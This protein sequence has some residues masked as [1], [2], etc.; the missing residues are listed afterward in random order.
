MLEFLNECILT[1]M[2]PLLGWLLYL[3]SDA[4]LIAI[5]LLSA[6]ALTG[7]RIVTTNQDLL[8]R[9][10]EDKRRLKELAAAAK[11]QGDKQARARYRATSTMIGIKQ[12]KAE[13]MPLVAV[14]LP[15]ILLVTWCFNRLD[16]HAVAPE[17]PVE[18]AVYLPLSAVGELAHIVPHEGITTEAGWLKEVILDPDGEQNG[19]VVWRLR[20]A[21]RAEPYTLLIRHKGATFKR[22]LR[23]D[24]RF[25]EPPL[26]FYDDRVLCAEIRLQPVKLFGIVPGLPALFLP[27]WMVAYLLLV[28]PLSVLLKRVVGVY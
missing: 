9:C 6:G 27:P 14:L 1:V 4:T 25:Y 21:A 18:L 12:L 24:R 17:E 19:L 16:Y 26:T 11:R 7:V 2:D 5:A 22:S 23:V 15:I 8:R 28:I 10:K 3:P 13:G 20:A